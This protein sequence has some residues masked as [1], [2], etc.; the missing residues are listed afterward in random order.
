MRILLYLSVESKRREARSMR[1]TRAHVQ[2]KGNDHYLSVNQVAVA[3]CRQA[4]VSTNREA[5]VIIVDE[6]R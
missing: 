2:A 3:H 5:I 6:M 1:A 4:C